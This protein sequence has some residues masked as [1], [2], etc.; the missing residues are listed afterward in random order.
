[1]LV[2]GN[3]CVLLCVWPGKIF[4][5]WQFF[6]LIFMLTDSRKRGNVSFQTVCF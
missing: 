6:G 4:S 1:M 3:S 5:K 2:G